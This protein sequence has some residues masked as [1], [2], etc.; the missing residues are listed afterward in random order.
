MRRLWCLLGGVLLLCACGGGGEES[1]SP[2]I[3]P[4]ATPTPST[5]VTAID[6]WTDEPVTTLTATPGAR[7]RVVADG[8]LQ[9]TQRATPTIH[10]WPELMPR[11]ILRGLVY[12]WANE[13]H[14][15]WRWREG[16]TVEGSDFRVPYV[17]PGPAVVRVEVNADDEHFTD[18]PRSVGYTRLWLSGG[19]I[20]RAQ[21]VVRGQRWNIPSVE[22]HEL[23]HAA[24]L[25]H[26]DDPSFLMHAVIEADNFT[27]P[28]RITLHMMYRHRDAGNELPDSEAGAAA[29]TERVYVID[30]P[31]H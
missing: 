1:A 23:G 16:F 19:W 12:T 11:H 2:T 27:A 9:R 25:G 4:A 10:L 15:L 26:V 3:P 13:L 22:R 30:C 29:A 20:T 24:G 21:V 6:G 17:P 14:P 31:P 5:T 7:V 18:N 28:E 8:Y